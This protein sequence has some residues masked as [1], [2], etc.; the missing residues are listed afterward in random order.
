MGEVYRAR[1]TR[2]DRDVAVKLLPAG[3][4]REPGARE[5][6]DREARLIS[7]LSHPHICPMYDV[8][9]YDGSAFIVMECLEGETLAVRLQRGALPVVQALRIATEVAAALDHAHR[10]GIVH[11]DLKPGNVMLTR[12]GAKLLDFGLAKAVSNPAEHDGLAVTIEPLTRAGVVIGTPQYMAPE[13]VRGHP[14]DHRTDIFAFGALLHEVITGQRAFDRRDPADLMAAVLNMPVPL[15][16]TLQPLAPPAL[17]H[18]VARCLE[19]DP[20]ERWQSAFDVAS[21]LRWIADTGTSSVTAQP[22]VAVIS[23][24]RRLSPLV[25]GVCGIL[26]GAAAYAV[27]SALLRQSPQAV[28]EIIRASVPL[29]PNAQLA[30]ARPNVAISPDGRFLAF[31]ALVDGASTL[32]VRPVDAFETT[33]VKGTEG[34]SGPFFSADGEWIGFF[35]NG[36]LMKASRSGGT[37]VVICEA[38]DVRG[39]TWG[40]DGTIV[41][42]PRLDAGLY[43]VPAAGGTPVAVTV[44]AV[45]RREKTHR[46]PEL[47]PDGRSVMFTVGTHDIATFDEASIVIQS[48]SGGASR[49]IITGG[50]AAKY[51]PS[52]HIVYA[53]G[54]TLLAVPFDINRLEV[55]GSPV[56]VVA[57]VAHASDYGRVEYDVSDTGTLVYFPGGDTSQHSVL[58]SVDR[59]GQFTALTSQPRLFLSV[60]FSPKAQSLLTIIGGA[61]DT[62]WIYDIQRDLP[63]RLTF[64]GNVTSASWTADGRRVVY[65]QAGELGTMSAD[66]SGH[67]EIIFRDDAQK[68]SP[69]L[70]P[71][72]ATLVFQTIQP[73]SGFDIW[74]MSMQTRQTTPWLSTPFNENRPRLSPNGRWVAYVSNESGRGEVYVRALISPGVKT[75]VSRDGGRLPT[76]S[77]DG[78]ELIFLQESTLMAV[79]VTTATAAFEAGRPYPLFNLRRLPV[80]EGAIYDVAPDGTRFVVIEPIATLVPTDA[81]VVAGWSREIARKVAVTRKA[82][83]N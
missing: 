1:D 23:T 77:A 62:G 50:V 41:F 68:G 21:E 16:S 2:L 9:E 20:D 51:L 34:A 30:A 82:P 44:P 5:R 27:G 13:Q 79:T 12:S 15:V 78:R 28:P 29:P 63:S 57:R 72:G 36:R 70:T 33:P 56:P 47:L 66:G 14:T 18:V 64:K 69:Q 3:F 24:R 19:K 17:D 65:S 31:V 48:L 53:R 39:A 67:E 10:Q 74:T 11:R 25:I 81:Y 80:D 60:E 43:R 49:T 26:A 8:G 42:S 35:A 76:W 52:G 61:N 59:R 83:N 32:F 71:D 45:E 75:Q 38:T 22:P 37:P 46:F 54:D 73:G 6:F 7:R 4:S 55:S 58:M 40:A